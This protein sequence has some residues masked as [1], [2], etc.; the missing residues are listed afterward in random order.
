V[1]QRNLDRI[2]EVEAGRG[3]RGTY[4]VVGSLMPELR[5]RIEANGHEVAFHS[6]DHDLEQPQLKRCRK[7]DYRIPGYRPPQSRM[8]AELNDLELAR[9]NFEWLAS[10]PKSV[11]TKVPEIRATIARIPVHFDDFPL[12][13]RGMPWSE[14]ESE[15]IADIEGR[16]TATFGMHDC[17]AHYWLDGYDEFLARL[18][19]LGRLRT[20]GDV[21]NDLFL[22]RAE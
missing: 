13:K 6:Y 7:L 1:S 22:C 2:L 3:A 12:Y 4:A 10:A 15:A 18:G 20:I 11:G 9:R 5:A 14:W 19:D 16:T 17:Y 8:T 21:A